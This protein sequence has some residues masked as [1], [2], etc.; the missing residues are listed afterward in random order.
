MKIECKMNRTTE[1]GI[2]YEYMH[3]GQKFEVWIPRRD[4]TSGVFAPQQ[5]NLYTTRKYEK[6]IVN[7]QEVR[8]LRTQVAALQDALDTARSQRAEAMMKLNHVRQAVS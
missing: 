8:A 2:I 3:K 1:H 7:E 6:P 5:M 4:F